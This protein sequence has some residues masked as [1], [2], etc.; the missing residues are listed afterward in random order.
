MTTTTD[1]TAGLRAARAKDSHDKRCRA[2]AAVHTLETAGTPVTAA[3][4]AR[5]AGVSTWLVYT[6]GMREHLEAARRRQAELNPPVSTAAP[7]AKPAPV[8]PASL[9]TDLALVRD[10]IRRLRAEHDRLRHRLRLQL[11]AE[12]DGP[13]RAE[14]IT[15][16]ADLESLAR[17]LLAERDA[18]TAEADVAQRR[19]TDLEDDLT[20]ARESLR[21]VIK[22]NNRP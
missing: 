19:I 16:V 12:I 17:Q 3:A 10:E 15:R 21:R 2:R 14:L 22:D 20:A 1:R 6:D 4:I 8:T 9:R 11:G 5:T 7:G 13:D 18:R